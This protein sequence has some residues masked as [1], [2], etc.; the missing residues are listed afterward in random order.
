MRFSRQLASL[1]RTVVQSRAFCRMSDLFNLKT[2]GQIRGGDIIPVGTESDKC[3]RGK[4]PCMHRKR[5]CLPDTVGTS[6]PECRVRD[7]KA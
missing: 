1:L 2:G 5:A 4:A 7:G 6:L 3:G